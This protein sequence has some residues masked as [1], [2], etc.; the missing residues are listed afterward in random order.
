MNLHFW[1]QAIAK[2]QHAD[3]SKTPWGCSA[4]AETDGA[5]LSFHFTRRTL[6]AAAA[7][8]GDAGDSEVAILAKRWVFP[9]YARV[10]GLPCFIGQKDFLNFN[11]PLSSRFTKVSS[12]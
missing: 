8:K 1:G 7:W 10:V 3:C 11:G 9:S 4:A 6:N 2:C 12:T 5:A